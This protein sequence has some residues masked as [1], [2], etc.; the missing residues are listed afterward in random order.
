MSANIDTLVVN[1]V[2]EVYSNET[3][4]LVASYTIESLPSGTSTISV[5]D[6]TVREI[7]EQTVWP[8]AQNNKIKYTFN[9]MQGSDLISTFSANKILVYDGY[10]N[11]TYAY[12]GHENII[13]RK[14]TISGDIIISTQP[15][16]SYKD[17]FSRERTETW[18]IETPE[19]AEV[20][21]ALLYFAYNWDTSYYP[22]GWTLE[23]SDA[24]ITGTEIS[25]EMDR[26]NLGYYGAY[27]YG[28]VVFDVTDYYKVNDENTFTITKTGNCALYPSTLFVLYNVTDSV[29]VKDVY[30]SDIC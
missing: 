2:L 22:D 4:A 10:F 18:N 6:P 29:T 25:Y 21:A 12:N 14:Y 27:N 8:A 26:G 17:Q 23:F 1:L 30:F 24:D 28:L 9:L 3:G 16:S 20:V 5:T 15:E 11:Q 19:D 13:N 7:T